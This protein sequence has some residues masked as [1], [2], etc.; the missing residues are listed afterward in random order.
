MTKNSNEPKK[1]RFTLKNGSELE[2]VLIKIYPYKGI[3]YLYLSDDVGKKRL[4][5]PKNATAI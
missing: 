1:Y 5:N 2:G 4:I 3:D